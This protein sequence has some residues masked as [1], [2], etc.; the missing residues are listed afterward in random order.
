M[1]LLQEWWTISLANHEELIIPRSIDG[2]GFNEESCIAWITVSASPS[3]NKVLSHF[4]FAFLASAINRSVHS[5]NSIQVNSTSALWSLPIKTRLALYFPI[6]ACIKILLYILGRKGNSDA[7]IF[8]FLGFVFPCFLVAPINTYNL[9]HNFYRVRHFLWFDHINCS[10][11]FKFHH[12]Q[13]NQTIWSY[14]PHFVVYWEPLKGSITWIQST[15][16]WIW[17]S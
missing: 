16:V 9:L 3:N 4:S 8:T 14:F 17:S 5:I 2:W 6:V 13:S 11:W 12:M 10:C 15:I 7:N 1:S